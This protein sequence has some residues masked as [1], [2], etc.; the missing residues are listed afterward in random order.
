MD[1]EHFGCSLPTF[2]L[3]DELREDITKHEKMWS[4][5]EEYSTQLEKMSAQDWISFRYVTIT[6]SKVLAGCNQANCH[7][8]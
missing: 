1:S 5:Y 3:L 6:F 7:H 4:L 8:D 2:P